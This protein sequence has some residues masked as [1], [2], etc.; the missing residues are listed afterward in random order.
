M[1]TRTN[2]TIIMGAGLAGLSAGCVLTRAGRTVLLVEGGP[3]VGGLSRTIEHEGFR[4]DLG[5]HRFITKT[6]ETED[7]VRRLLRDEC[8]T[9][10]RKSEICMR[11]RRFDYPLTPANAV[12]GMGMAMTF[13][14]LVDYA[15][16][17]ARNWVQRP[18]IISLEDWVV[19]RF[20]RTMF[21]LYF[22]EYSE[23]VWGISC[24]EISMEWVSRR[25]EGLSL[26]KAIKNAF[27]KRSGR[28][29]D[30]LADSFLYPATGIGLISE[31]LREEIEINN[32]VRT[33]TRV[34]RV[35]HDDFAIKSIMVR[36]GAVL[37]DL[38]GSEF[39]SSI[40]LTVLVQALHPAPPEDV[41][42]AVAQLRYRDLV[43]STIMLDR[44]QVTD[45]T[46]MYLPEKTI[47]FG[48]IHE[49]KNWSKG[50]APPGKTHLVA[51]YFCS[52]QDSIW[53]ASNEAITDSTVE[54]LCR[55]GLINRREVI[56]S[57]IVRVPGAYPLFQVGYREHYEK[58]MEYLKRFRNLH[59]I[60]RGGMFRYHNMDHAMESGIEAAEAI[61]K[62][63]VRGEE[64]A[65]EPVDA[66][67]R[68]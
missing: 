67:S 23:K 50:M 21:D 37:Y 45:L 19:G 62:E 3:A 63:P 57:C 5:G 34:S 18:A 40:P 1:D 20:G 46:W 30:T 64:H 8:L 61:L 7:F 11:G 10:P 35:D 31:R 38:K 59:V 36:N 4:F 47:P 52:Q 22:R 66:S 68:V 41:Q 65:P 39:V 49:P 29:I 9:V 26:W 56:G 27:S 42:R 17:N 58:I 14:I 28:D 60:G 16:Q 53:K 32:S 48:R 13:R 25:I 15:L 24:R 6:R 12:F 44:D 54:H 2:S 51:E 55:M 33:N 43:V